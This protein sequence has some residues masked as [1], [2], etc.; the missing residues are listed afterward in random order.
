[1]HVVWDIEKRFYNLIVCL[2][3]KKKE[4]DVLLRINRSMSLKTYCKWS[5]ES[6]CALKKTF[7]KCL[8]KT[9]F[10]FASVQQVLVPS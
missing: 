2:F 10:F 5:L 9:H 8:L 7:L 4:Y 3:F 6:K 1:M